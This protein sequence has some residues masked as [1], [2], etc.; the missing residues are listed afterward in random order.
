M[1][2]NKSSGAHVI[3]KYLELKEDLEEKTNAAHESD[4]LYRCTVQWRNESPSDTTD[5]KGLMARLALLNKKTPSAQEHELQLFL[6]ADL[7]FKTED[8]VDQ[9]FPLRWWKSHS[10][11]YPTLAV[12]ARSYLATSASSCCV[13]RL[14]SAAADVCSNS[15]GRLLSATMSRSVNSLMWLREDIPLTGAFETAGKVLTDLIPK[16]KNKKSM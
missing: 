12:M 5:P 2:G 6:T 7:T 16:K 15:R 4:A 13:E 14:F 10:N 11:L 1:E 9:D 8:I 3:P